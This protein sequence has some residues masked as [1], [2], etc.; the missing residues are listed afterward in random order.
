MVTT[1]VAIF[2]LDICV[3]CEQQTTKI[4]ELPLIVAT[5]AVNKQ[6]MQ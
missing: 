1:I 6:V 3:V 4:F 5:V 2:W